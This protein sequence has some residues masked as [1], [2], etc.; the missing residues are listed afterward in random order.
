MASWWQQ[1]QNK[2]FKRDPGPLGGPVKIGLSSL[3]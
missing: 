3:Y 1:K 2:M